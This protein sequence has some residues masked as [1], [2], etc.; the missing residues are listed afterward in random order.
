MIKYY[1]GDIFTSNA[2]I[3]CHQV[4][5]Q[6]VFNKGMA[7]QVK[8]YFPEV[9]KTY[10]KITKQWV[11]KANGD[12]SKLLGAV[13]AQ[14]VEKDGRWFLIA[15]LYGQD[16]YG[17][18]GVFTDYKALETAMTEIRSFLDARDKSETAAFPYKIGCG[19]AG[20]EWTVVEEIIQKVFDDYT[21]EI[22]IWKLE[23]EH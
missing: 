20:G 14:P 18:K 22:Q 23:E 4:N 2:D 10:K 21:G 7:A 13:S 11:D 19:R 9:E 8:K 17:K 12:T 16:D 6:G 5:C 3:I 15:N 1:D